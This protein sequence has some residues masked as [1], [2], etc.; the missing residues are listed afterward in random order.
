MLCH[1]GNSIC[2]AP[3]AVPALL[4]NGATLGSC[5]EQEL[6][7]SIEEV[8]AW[9]NPAYNNSQIRVTAG[10]SFDAV[11]A[12]YNINGSPVSQYEIEVKKGSTDFDLNLE[13]LPKGIYLVKILANGFE[14]QGLK[15]IKK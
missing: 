14:S 10:K 11:M 7:V 3:Q 13:N 8:A 1:N 9:P 5:E 15:L 12:L 6:E 4:R 2:V